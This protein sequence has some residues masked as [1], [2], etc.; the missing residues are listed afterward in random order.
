MSE[1]ASKLRG[2]QLIHL[3]RGFSELL[4]K[5]WEATHPMDIN[6]Q[7]GIIK[8]LGLKTRNLTFR[9]K[10]KVGANPIFLAQKCDCQSL[11]ENY[12]PP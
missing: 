10:L 8:A 5:L 1:L 7:N 4:L 9:G 2:I 11:N 6:R 12:F 3:K